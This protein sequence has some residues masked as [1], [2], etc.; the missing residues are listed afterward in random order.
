MREAQRL[1]KMVDSGM[2]NASR[3]SLLLMKK[4]ENVLTPIRP[5]L[6]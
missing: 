2:Q 3:T 4:T 6:S 5:S 1:C